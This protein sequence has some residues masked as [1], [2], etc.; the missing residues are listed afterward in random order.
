MVFTG[1][2]NDT[3]VEPLCLGTAVLIWLTKRCH[4]AEFGTR[5]VEVSLNEKK[6]SLVFGSHLVSH[7]A[8][9]LA[10]YHDE[11]AAAS[12]GLLVSAQSGLQSAPDWF[13]LIEWTAIEDQSRKITNIFKISRI[14][15][16]SKKFQNFKSMNS[17]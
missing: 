8:M 9:E 3:I 4:R 2:G 7:L 17:F 15:V 11:L 13:D 16:L 10:W 6:R 1:P 12:Q 5:A 14:Y